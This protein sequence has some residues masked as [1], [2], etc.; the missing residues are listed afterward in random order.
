[1]RMDN[2]KNTENK[3]S[4]SQ[5][6][7]NKDL[8]KDEGLVNPKKSFLK[9]LATRTLAVAIWDGIKELGNAFLD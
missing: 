8:K 2:R 9:D 3:E 4:Q 6:R 5:L 1:M 7:M